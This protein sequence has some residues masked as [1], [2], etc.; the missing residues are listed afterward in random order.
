MSKTK[1]K[2]N[3]WNAA[4]YDTHCLECG[5][6]IAKGDNVIHVRYK[7]AIM[8]M[9]SYCAKDQIGEVSE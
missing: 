9:C 4:E 2:P 7:G 3:D 1:I 8:Y 6:L 5:G